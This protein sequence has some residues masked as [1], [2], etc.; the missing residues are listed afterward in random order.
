MLCLFPFVKVCAFRFGRGFGILVIVVCLLIF[1]LGFYFRALDYPREKD[2]ARLQMRLSYSPVAH[3]F[4]FLVQWTDCHLAGLLGLL[5][6]H[7]YM[8]ICFTYVY[9]TL[10][11]VLLVFVL[12]F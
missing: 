4:L 5:R 10:L 2:G 7:I 8:V 3:L 9:L 12:V 6:I 1:L 11:F